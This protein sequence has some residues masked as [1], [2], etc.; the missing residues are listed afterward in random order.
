MA[1]S[2]FTEGFCQPCKPKRCTT[3]LVRPLDG[4]NKDVGGTSLL[5]TATSVYL[6]D[7]V[8]ICPLLKMQHH[9]LCPNGRRNPP[10]ASHPPPTHPP[11]H[12]PPNHPHTPN[13]PPTRNWP[14][15]LIFF[16]LLCYATLLIKFTYYAQNYAEE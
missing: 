14:I 13:H 3:E 7:C 8:C 4:I 5:L 12:P 15:M 11:T 2:A 16:Y 10:L 6:V 9:C 1:K